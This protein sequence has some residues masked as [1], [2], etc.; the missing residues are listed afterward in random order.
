MPRWTVTRCTLPEIGARTEVAAGAGEHDRTVGGVRGDGAELGE[1]FVPHRGV[2]GVLL[3]R[4]PQRDRDH[5]VGAFH[6]DRFELAS[7]SGHA[8]R[9]Y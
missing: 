9:R 2:C 6:R 5:P 4:T 8:G 7:V 1:Q 3:L